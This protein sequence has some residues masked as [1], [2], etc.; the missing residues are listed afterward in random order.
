[1]NV[2][3]GP[4]GILQIDD[5]RIIYCNFAGE[6]RSEFDTKGDRNFSL[7]IPNQMMTIE[8]DFGVVEDEFGQ[9]LQR[10]LH[11]V[12]LDLGWN[13]KIKPARTKDEEDFMTLRV[14]VKFNERGPSAYLSSGANM[15]KLD[16]Q[17]I[18]M[19]DNIL[20]DKVNL[21]IRPYDWELRGER[22]RTAYL[23]SIH[24]TQRIEDRFANLYNQRNA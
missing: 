6:K 24:V 1:M 16:E 3:F 20:I 14:K 18:G 4:R 9:P 8:D 23:H 21:D 15:I 22:G 17:T 10:H 2:T 7:V 13:V 11:E 19:L 12:L 5:A